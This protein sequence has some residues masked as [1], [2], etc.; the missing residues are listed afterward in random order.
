MNAAKAAEVLYT[1]RAEIPTFDQS[2]FDTVYRASQSSVQARKA[3]RIEEA[4]VLRQ[5]AI[6]AAAL[7][8]RWIE[9][10]HL[11]TVLAS[12]VGLGA[13]PVIPAALVASAIAVASLVVVIVARRADF[14]SV[15]AG[16]LAGKIPDD[17]VRKFLPTDWGEVAKFGA[18]AVGLWAVVKLA[19]GFR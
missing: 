6:D 9:T 12:Y 2:L 10:V 17:M 16:Y 8:S 18:V 7:R 19:D 1:Y 13:V 11:W 5:V 14:E 3:G 4:D 15:L